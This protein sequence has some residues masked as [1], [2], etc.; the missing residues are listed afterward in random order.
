VKKIFR[1]LDVD[2]TLKGD[3]FNTLLIFGAEI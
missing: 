3:S 2:Y 1:W